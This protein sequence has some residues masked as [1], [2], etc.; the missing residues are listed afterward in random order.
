MASVLYTVQV[1]SAHFIHLVPWGLPLVCISIHSCHVFHLTADKALDFT[2]GTKLSIYSMVLLQIKLLSS[3]I[4]RTRVCVCVC[5][6]RAV[7]GED[8]LSSVYPYTHL[9]FSSSVISPFL[10]QFPEMTHFI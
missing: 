4:K 5:V 2:V 10:F 6:V 1:R 3:Q 8:K 9:S 7:S